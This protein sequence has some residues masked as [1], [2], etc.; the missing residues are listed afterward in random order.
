MCGFMVRMICN[1]TQPSKTAHGKPINERA[2]EGSFLSSIQARPLPGH[3]S[4]HALLAEL[5]AAL[6]HTGQPTDTRPRYLS[7]YRRLWAGGKAL[8]SCFLLPALPGVFQA[9]LDRHSDSCPIRAAEWVWHLEVNPS[10]PQGTCLL[11]RGRAAEV[12]FQTRLACS[13][14]SGAALLPTLFILSSFLTSRP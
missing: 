12:H 3:A 9:Q 7:G 1:Q 10:P 2:S 5:I 4:Q 13:D 11:S 6:I 14:W 8:R